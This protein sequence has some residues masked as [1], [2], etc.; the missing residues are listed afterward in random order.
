[1]KNGE[2]EFHFQ[3]RGHEY[4]GFFTEIMSN[5]ILW[6]CFIGQ[7]GEDRW[8]ITTCRAFNSLTDTHWFYDLSI[9]GTHEDERTVLFKTISLD[10]IKPNTNTKTNTNTNPIQLFYAFFEHRPLIFSLALWS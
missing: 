7:F 1:M 3:F 2:N 10:D 5:H 6:S 8:T 4:Y 9:V